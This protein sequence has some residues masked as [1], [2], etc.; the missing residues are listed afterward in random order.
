MTRKE[1][2]SLGCIASV[3]AAFGLI[4]AP[5]SLA[6]G[7]AAGYER[8]GMGPTS[9]SGAMERE[10]TKGAPSSSTVLIE[11]SPSTLDDYAVY[12]GD[13]LQAAAMQVKQEGSAEVKLTINKDGSIR[14]TE[15]IKVSGPPAL[16]DRIPQLVNQIQPLPPLPGNVDALV[17][18]ADLTLDYP[19]P[20]LYDRFGRL[21]R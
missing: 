1:R 17:V 18:T 21:P 2:R 8:G 5:F 9:R 19:G 4:A 14:Q 11:R 20:N 10:T 12:V 15:V 6:T 13:R 7:W 16:R 3:I